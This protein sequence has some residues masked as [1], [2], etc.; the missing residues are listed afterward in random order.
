LVNTGGNTYIRYEKGQCER[1]RR[2][3]NT[4][5]DKTSQ[6]KSSLPFNKR[7]AHRCVGNNIETGSEGAKK[8]VVAI[9]EYSI[10]SREEL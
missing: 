8:R 2:E 4:E 9:T 7:S 6:N 3:K 1:L 5:D 10:L